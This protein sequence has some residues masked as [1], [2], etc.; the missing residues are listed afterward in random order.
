MQGGLHI[1][2]PVKI[3]SATTGD[4][5]RASAVLHPT[6]YVDDA[7]ITRL[8]G[9]SPLSRVRAFYDRE[10]SPR[11]PPK[12]ISFERRTLTESLWRFR[13]VR[14]MKEKGTFFLTKME[15]AGLR[16]RG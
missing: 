10:L 15:G 8:I 12:R 9:E 11:R 16:L 2:R 4:K 3:E 5:S 6:G 13:V 1:V 14:P 7:I